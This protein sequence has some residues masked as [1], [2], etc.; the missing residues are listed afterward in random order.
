MTARKLLHGFLPA[1]APIA[2]AIAGCGGG[3]NSDASF[4]ANVNA[5]CRTAQS[6][7][8]ALSQPASSSAA[9]E[10]AYFKKVLPL[11]QA[12]GDKIKTISAP[13]DKAVDFAAATANH[14][15]SIALLKQAITAADAGDKT[16]LNLVLSQAQALSST[17]DSLATKIGVTDCVSKN[18]GAST[19]TSTTT[20]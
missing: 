20:T 18:S 16:A 4:I 10:G 19:S 12:E 11:V 6:Q 5:Q 7:I 9:D 13:S 2:L 15:Q 17:G 8:D 3:G 14:D 1:V